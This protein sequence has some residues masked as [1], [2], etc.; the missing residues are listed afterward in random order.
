MVAQLTEIGHELV[1][2]A[3]Y[4]DGTLRGH[5]IDLGGPAA[6]ERV[7]LK[8][9]PITG[10]ACSCCGRPLIAT[11]T[12]LD[13]SPRLGR[14]VLGGP[15]TDLVLISDFLQPSQSVARTHVSNEG[16]ADAVLDPHGALLMTGGWDGK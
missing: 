8:I 14:L 6:E 13:Y 4:D 1:L 15:H 2:L 3:G 11:V 9:F 7:R 10:T 16:F 12:C 5:A